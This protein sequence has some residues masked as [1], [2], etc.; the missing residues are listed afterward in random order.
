MY[1]DEQHILC[2]H[3]NHTRKP[4]FVWHKKHRKIMSQKEIGDG[5]WFITIRDQLPHIPETIS[6][7]GALSA[8]GLFRWFDEETG[9][10]Y[11]FLPY[12]SPS[13]IDGLSAIL[14]QTG[15]SM[16]TLVHTAKGVC[17]HLDPAY[18]RPE[19]ISDNNFPLE[20]LGDKLSFLYIMA[21]VYGK[22][23]IRKD[24][25]FSMQAFVPVFG[26]YSFLTEK[27]DYLK[28]ALEKDG[29]FI[30]TKMTDTKLHI[31]S[32]DYDL[33]QYITHIHQNIQP[34]TSIAEKEKN[35][36]AINALI[37]FLETGIT[38]DQMENID[39]TNKKDIIETLQT[40]RC[41]ILYT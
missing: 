12:V 38:D 29:I 30:T 18:Q 21:V 24:T 25:L 5:M 2:T 8:L 39:I 19:K 35:Q 13:K 34:I 7:H 20:T 23:D 40:S 16:I 4:I 26:A 37:T 41:K 36:I 27:I 1:I 17:V 10:V 6:T 31:Q 14:S 32:N 15:L 33:S 3:A 9:E 22:L 28:K 11:C